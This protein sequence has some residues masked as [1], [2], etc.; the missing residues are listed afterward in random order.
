MIDFKSVKKVKKMGV[1][2][3]LELPFSLEAEQ[4]VLGGLLLDSLSVDPVLEIIKHDDFYLNEH[5][6]IFSAMESLFSQ[7]KPIDVTTVSAYLRGIGVLESIGGEQYLYH[8]SNFIP[9]L[10]N[11]SAYAHIV[12]DHSILRKLIFAGNEII[13]EACDTEGRNTSEILEE[14]EKKIFSISKQEFS[15]NQVESIQSILPA[16]L[17]TISTLSKS[18]S[19]I[20]GVATG[21]YDFDKLTA[22]LQPSELII[23]AGRPSMGKTML[24]MN[25]AQNIAINNKLPVLVFSMEMSKQSLMMRLIS[26]SSRTDFY[27]VRTGNLTDSDWS[28]MGS[29]VAA[30]SDSS[31]F[32]DDTP[33]LSPTKLRARARRLAK[34]KG[35]LGLIVIDYLQLMQLSGYS[36]NRATEIS[37][38]S[39][40]LKAL[41]KELNVPILA[42]SQLNRSLEQRSDKRPIMSDLRD[43]G[44]IE[45]DADLIAFIYRDEV[46]N[47]NSPDVG[48]AEIIISKQRNGSIGKIKLKFSGEFCRFDNLS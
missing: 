23:V 12:H 26:S 10:A 36:E 41:A 40:S 17:E 30:L 22:G 14:V 43:S 4:S 34:E 19:F 13:R 11:I 38:I 33:A 20:T 6:A 9:S 2:K 3:A 37:E 32:I 28:L 25:I 31:I 18:K 16:T 48:T 44:G 27:R 39:R 46:Y 35:K 47:P 21:Y 7:N 5:K 42:L 15:N 45:Q 8:L 24:A 29:S 1:N